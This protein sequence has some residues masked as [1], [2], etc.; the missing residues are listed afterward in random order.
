MTNYEFL[1]KWQELQYKISFDQIIDLKFATISYDKAESSNF[2]NFALVDQLL[3]ND[4]IKEVE[5]LFISRDRKP[6]IFFENRSDLENLKEKLTEMS[7][8]KS[9]EDSW[10][11]YISTTP[12]LDSF[13][14]VKKVENNEDLEIFL[15]VFDRSYVVDDP[16]NPYGD[17]KNFIPS[18][19]KSW[20]EFGSSNRIEYFIVY[21]NGKPGAVSA[22]NSFGNIG[23]ISCV[24]SLP[25]FRGL[26]LGKTATLYSV[27]ESMENG[28]SIHCL[29]TEE[30]TYPNEFYKRIGFETKF[31]AI[32][33]I[34]LI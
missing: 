27:K 14:S 30:G 6:S 17:V 2:S 21:N 16:K 24:G 10:M 8:R 32:N 7:Y 11:F 12:D 25:E 13:R 28:N 3:S 20:K 19:R 5:D 18:A 4:Q 1:K 15:D 22:L 31:R 26:G 34:K 9:F 33:M 23:Y 29:A